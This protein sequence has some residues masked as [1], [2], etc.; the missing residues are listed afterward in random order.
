MAEGVDFETKSLYNL[1]VVVSDR[2]VPQRSSSVAAVIMIG[3]VND[4]PPAFTRAEY[5][6]SLS[7]GATAG[8]EIIRLSATGGRTSFYP[9]ASKCLSLS[10]ISQ[11]YN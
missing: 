10:L 3:D 1:T 11:L 9:L 4:N 7:E 2:G 5:T 8:T 6:V